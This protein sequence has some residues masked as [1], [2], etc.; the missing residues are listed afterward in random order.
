MPPSK[1]LSDQFRA[2]ID[3]SSMTRYR[4]CK[5]LDFSESVMSRF[6]S[7]KCGLSLETLD[8]LGE[9]LKLEIKVRQTGGKPKRKN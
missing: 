7:G 6:M 3:A 8:R 2:A 9:L 1:K 5:E 4:I